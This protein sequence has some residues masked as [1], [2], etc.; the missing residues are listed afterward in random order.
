MTGFGNY[1]NINDSHALNYG[2]SYSDS[3]NNQNT[4]HLTADNTN[5]I[6]QSITTGYDFTL[7][8]TISTSVGLG[9]GDSD[10]KDDT[11]DFKNYDFRIFFELN[12]LHE[13]LIFF[14][15]SGCVG[16]L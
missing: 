14:Q 10:A 7:N 4:G 2:Y 11:N 5:T 8:E 12:F 1:Y 3:K 15:N 9:Y 13:F 6:S 16:K